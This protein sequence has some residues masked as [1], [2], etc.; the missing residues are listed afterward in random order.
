[1]AA[2]GEPPSEPWRRPRSMLLSSAVL[3]RAVAAAFN[4]FL[5]YPGHPADYG[6]AR[7][8]AIRAALP[9]DRAGS[10]RRRSSS[11]V[12]P[13]WVARSSRRCST[14]CV[15]N[16]RGRLVSFNLAQPLLQ[17]E[18]ALAMAKSIRETYE[19]EQAA[20]GSPSSVSRSRS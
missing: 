16:S 8:R 17:P 5:P 20:S 13:E 18:T 2:E 12:A 19:A 1:M 4:P 7:S 9:G 3:V 10:R 11:S 14:R 15:G 6:I